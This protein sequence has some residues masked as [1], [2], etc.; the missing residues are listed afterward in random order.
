MDNKVWLLD[1]VAERRNLR[2][3]LITTKKIKPEWVLVST[4]TPTIED[5]LHALREIKSVCGCNTAIFGVHASYFRRDLIGHPFIDVVIRGEPEMCARELVQRGPEGVRGI[6]YK[7]GEKLVETPPRDFLNLNELPYPAWDLVDLKN[8]KT[9]L[10]N[11]P[12]VMVVT[13]RGCPHKCTFCTGPY[14]YGEKPRKR[15]IEQIVAEIEW[16]IKRFKVRD[17][18]FFEETFTLDKG[19]VLNLCEELIARGL[20]VR[21]MCN[22]RVDSIDELLAKRMKL[23]GC[24]LISFGM[25][26]ASEEVL[27]RAKKGT[28]PEQGRTAISMAKKAGL[29]TNGIF[30]LGLPGENVQTL[31]ATI[32]FAKEVGLDF[33]EFT[34][35]T[36]FP[37]SELYEEY[38]MELTRDWKRY[39]YFS[40][41]IP[42]R[43]NLRKWQLLAYLN[44]YLRS[45][46]VK[47]I[48]R[49][50]RSV[51]GQS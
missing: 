10:L 14:Y 24:W 4:S 30:T 39:E 1:A 48:F 50:R 32:K 13:G 49:L 29:I 51:L 46:A 31:K 20:H 9:P 12:F 25:E 34:I 2:E 11:T 33:A 16:V 6:L 23:A 28:T 38:K 26:S 35:A 7:V 18:L 21:W 5:D 3:I 43:L 45:G 42:T 27:N 41:V 47:S 44:F 19:F 15:D 22:S 40:Q 37:G 8:Y 36:P 17:F